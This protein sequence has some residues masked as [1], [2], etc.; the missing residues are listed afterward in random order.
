MYDAAVDHNNFYG[1][2]CAGFQ[3]D[4]YEAPT[5]TEGYDALSNFCS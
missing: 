4:T 3:M 1:R 2:T 5:A